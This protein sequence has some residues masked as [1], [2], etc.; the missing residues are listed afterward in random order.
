LLDDLHAFVQDHER[1]GELDSAVEGDRVWI[2]A[3]R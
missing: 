2:R 1:C 3:A